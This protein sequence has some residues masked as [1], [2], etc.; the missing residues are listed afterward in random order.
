MN[1]ISLIPSDERIRLLESTREFLTVDEIKS[2]VKSS[3]RHEGVK[4]AYLF[5]CLSGLRLSDIKRLCWKNISKEQSQWR[6]SVL[7]KKTQRFLHLPLSYEAV[8]LLPDADWENPEVPVFDL[9]GDEQINAIL[10]KW[11]AE[12][13]IK[14]HI[15][16]HT[17]KHHT[18]SI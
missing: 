8:K 14:K 4:K 2:L 11:V 13:G 18:I 15:T 6:I 1:P 12:N 9:P 17:A 7:M 16:F 3:C 5:S 10:K